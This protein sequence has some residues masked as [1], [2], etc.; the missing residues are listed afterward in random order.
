MADNIKDAIK[1][2]S[3]N[4]EDIKEL[5]NLEGGWA[6]TCDFGDCPNAQCCFNICKCIVI[7]I[8]D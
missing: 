4:A 2:V 6:P 7:N 5:S 1:A 3:K 8:C